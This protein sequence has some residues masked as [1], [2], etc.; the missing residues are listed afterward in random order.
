MPFVIYDFATAFILNFLIYEDNFILF[1]I[2]VQKLI[3]LYPLDRFFFLGRKKIVTVWHQ[4]TE[5]HILT[6]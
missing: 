6:H 4:R 1:F 5:S 3:K 2:S